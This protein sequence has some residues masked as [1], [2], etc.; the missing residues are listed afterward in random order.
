MAEV[1]GWTLQE[2][3]DKLSRT[4]AFYWQKRPHCQ[5]HSSHL[6]NRVEVEKQRRQ[7]S[8]HQANL[9]PPTPGA[10]QGR[11]ARGSRL[12]H[13]TR[14]RRQRRSGLGNGK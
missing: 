12:R 1:N 9:R 4:H 13:R 7:G 8:C 2:T 3:H 14:R 10:F 5:N 11:Q 6:R